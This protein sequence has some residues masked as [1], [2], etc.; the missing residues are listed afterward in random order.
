MWQVLAWSQ[1]DKSS[2]SSVGSKA[3]LWEAG[4]S[5]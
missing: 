4:P 5:L 2:R 1:A 3:K